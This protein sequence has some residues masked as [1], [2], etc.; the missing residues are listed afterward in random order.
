MIKCLGQTILFLAKFVD[1]TSH[2]NSILMLRTLFGLGLIMVILFSSCRE[3]QT[4][5]QAQAK[6]LRTKTISYLLAQQQ[7]DGSWRSTTHGILKGGVAYTAYL[8]DALRE[9]GDSLV[10]QK[11]IDR[12]IF[13][14]LSQRDSNGVVGYRNQYVVEYPVYANAYFCKM[15]PH[16]SVAFDTIISP[17]VELYL[18][19]Q[20]FTEQRGIGPEH[21]AYGAWGFGEE[22]LPK[23]Q[24]GHVDLSHTRRV[25]EALASVRGDGQPNWN[26][27]AG[28]LRRIQNEDGGFCSS[29]YTLGANKAD[30]QEQQCKSYATATADGI[31]ALLCLPEP[32]LEPVEAAA[33]WLIQHEGWEAPSGISP[34]QPGDWDKVLFF[35]HLAVKAQAYAKLETLSLL[36][37]H[38][39]VSWRAAVVQ[40]LAE[41][42]KPD[43]SFAN[44]WGA[45]NKED[46]PLLASGL[47][48]RALNAVLH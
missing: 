15:L 39:Q 34:N 41:R 13:F 44:P 9:S 1:I 46:D 12:A 11:H 29:S 22:N 27:A 2:Q 23:G 26:A 21:Q 7:Q 43:G 35:Y 47:A 40:L 24:V 6:Q 19:Q 45:P 3:E 31:L 10:R 8:S 32:P 5:W 14:L 36:P 17:Y 16:R 38:T 30:N 18:L 20:Q 4:D 25:M 28:F 48:L 37:S 42:Q 33:N